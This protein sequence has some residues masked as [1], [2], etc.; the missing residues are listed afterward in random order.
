MDVTIDEIQ[1]PGLLSEYAGKEVST[2]GV[3]T[4]H[5]RK[6]FFLQS[7]QPGREDASAAI[8]VYSPKLKLTVGYEV[9]VEGKVIDYCATSHDR[10]STQLQLQQ[11]TVLGRPQQP[12]AVTWLDAEQL[13]ADSEHVGRYL[14]RLEGM[15]VGIKR[16]ATFVAPSNS[17][18]DYVVVPEGWPGLRTANGGLLI[19]PQQPLRWL[20]SFRVL[21]YAKAPRVNVGARLATDVVDP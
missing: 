1:G 19:D 8:F 18:G 12:V 11:G 17:F 9:A 4:G 16:G 7:T 6:G 14:N 2:R 10:P 20:P 3:V 15:L 5:S 21:D 13:T